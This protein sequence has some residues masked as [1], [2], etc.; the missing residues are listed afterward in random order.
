MGSLG[1]ALDLWVFRPALGW[2]T[3]ISFDR[4]RM[5]AESDLDP[6]DSRNRWFMD[7]AA[8]AG[9]VLTAC[10][11]FRQA[12]AGRTPAP[13][14]LGLT[15]AAASWFLPAHWTVPRAGR[16]LRRS[17]DLNAES[18]VGSSRGINS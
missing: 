18:G 7:A 12:L 16:R 6:G 8:R 9:G 14:A 2:A 13:A 17:P 10:I 3:A 15:G 4:L 5:W 11:L 1:K